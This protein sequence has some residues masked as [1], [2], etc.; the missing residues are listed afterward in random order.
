ME[1]GSQNGGLGPALLGLLQHSGAQG[2]P[3]AGAPHSRGTATD[4]AS[5]ESQVLRT[6][7]ARAAAESGRV[8]PRGSFLDITA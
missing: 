8:F 5:P 2:S 3:S 7:A 6:D 1:I 4:P